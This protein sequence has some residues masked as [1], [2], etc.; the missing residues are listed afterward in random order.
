MRLFGFV[1]SCA[2]L[3]VCIRF[4]VEAGLFIGKANCKTH[5]RQGG[6][7]SVDGREGTISLDLRPEHSFV[8]VGWQDDDSESEV[9]SDLR[10][11]PMH[12]H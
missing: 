6:K 1:C 7:V 10:I 12:S 11:N 8:K 9:V 3:H 2:M 4:Q 5:F